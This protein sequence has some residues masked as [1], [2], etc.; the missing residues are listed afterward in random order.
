MGTRALA[1]AIIMQSMEDLSDT[2]Y[3]SESIDFFTGEGFGICAGM[4]GM[5]I[6]DKLKVMGLVKKLSLQ[7]QRQTRVLNSQTVQR[8]NQ[9]LVP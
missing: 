8:F 6:E 5:D 3:R 7:G 2:R 4:A 9:A 1:E